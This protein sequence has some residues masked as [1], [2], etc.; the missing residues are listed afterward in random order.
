MYLRRLAASTLAIAA[1]SAAA[2]AQ[3]RDSAA[4]SNDPRVGLAGGWKD[5]KEFNTRRLAEEFIRRFQTIAEA[6]RG[7]DWEYVGWYTEMLGLAERGEL[8][9]AYDDWFEE[10]DPRWL[11]TTKGFQS[12]LPMPPP[13]EAEPFP[14]GVW[15]DDDDIPDE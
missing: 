12:G 5:A 6:G 13:G 11:P 14:D 10:P 15:H 8:P 1:L 7:R 9:V 2:G 4:A 3:Q